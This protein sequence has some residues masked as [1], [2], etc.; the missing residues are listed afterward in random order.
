MTRQINAVEINTF[1]G[2]LITEASPLTFPPNASLDEDNFVL[3]R[4]G[5][6]YRRLGMDYESGWNNVVTSV[7]APATGEVAFTSRRWN[8]AGGDANRNLLVVQVGNQVKIFNA[9]TATI[10]S[11]VIF[12]KTF[13]QVAVDKP[14]SYAVVDGVMVI[15]TGLKS[16]TLFK[17][18]ATG[19]TTE[20]KTLLIRDLFGVTDVTDGVNL[21]QGS[22][23]T[24]RPAT[25]TNA[26][27]YNLRNQSFAVPHKVVTAEDIRDPIAHF[28][29]V[30]GVEPSNSDA[31][32]TALYP[33]ANDADDRLSDRFN[34]IDIVNNPL[35]SFPASR[36]Y[37]IIDAMA[38]G[39]S[40][41]QEVQKLQ[42]QYPVL[43][44]PVTGLPQDTTPGGPSVISEYSGRVF[45]SGFSGE[46]LSGD[47][48]SPRMSSYV[49]FSQL[50][51]DPTDITNCYQ[52]GDPTSKDSPDLL[53]TDGGFI[54][55]EGAY[56]IVKLINIGNAI[57]V[58]AAN[59]VWLIQGGSDYGFKATNYMTTKVT[60]HG[61]DSPDSVIGIDNTFMYWSDDGI[62]N[63]APNQFGDYI[64]EN[65]SQKTVQKY[66]DAIDG[67]DR[68]ACKGTYDTYEKKV[69]WL[70]G[71][72]LG[73]TSK[74]RELVLDTTIG[75]FYP[76][77]LGFVTG[78]LPLVA[79][80]VIVPPFRTTFVS[81]PVT[82]STA[83][84]TASGVPVTIAQ[85][86]VSP[87]TRETIYVVITGTSPTISFTF[88]SYKD[89]Y[90]RDWRSFNGVGVDA[91][92]FLLTGY[93]SANDFQRNKQVPYITMHLSKTE[94]GFTDAYEPIDPSSCLMQ[95]QWD[96]SNSENSGKW[97][98]TVQ[99]YRHRRHYMPADVNDGFDDGNS[100]VR[101]RNKLRG[102]G[103]VLSL[104][105]KS[106]PDMHLHILGWSMIMGINSNV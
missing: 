3:D 32:T 40:R 55:I 27:V 26:H 39:T 4:N 94:T 15:A 66:Y 106:E 62:Y 86:V 71:G 79:A 89:L 25:R 9:S 91:P 102:S 6:R 72:R 41:L 35:G 74:V 49:L 61:C 53:D 19:I 105:F 31:V 73:S 65:I 8:N 14:F 21:R 47:D 56:G 95:A 67:L 45:Y 13:D 29:A 96:W 54:R 97:G 81:N 98:R 30:A 11:S 10:S 93:Q 70:Y 88:G 75:A 16:I 69:R 34:A 68:R 52:D 42:A 64:A 17:Y 37:F 77:T 101:T 100:T 57:A 23:I 99:V 33:D 90:H 103:K 58:L 22:G 85:S 2:G 50:V 59:G 36:G 63:V 1:V 5:S 7:A 43:T 82:V 24:I 48:N 104:L 28:R 44:V 92:A 60:T 46:I 12:T 78:R 87:S 80:G 18:T 51:E 76:A 84:V 20:D 38:R 83:A